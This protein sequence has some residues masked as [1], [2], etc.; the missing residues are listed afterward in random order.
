MFFD[1]IIGS[2]SQGKSYDR[3]VQ[4]SEVLGD[5]KK[6]FITGDPEY[7]K[8]QLQDLM[9]RFNRITSYNVCYTKLLRVAMPVSG[10]KA[11]EIS[12]IDGLT[13]SA[14][15]NAM[16][17]ERSFKVKQL[18]ENEL[19]GI[20]EQLPTPDMFPLLAFDVDSGMKLEE[21]FPGEIELTFDLDIL[22]ISEAFREDLKIVRLGDT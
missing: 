3:L 22:N 6:T 2:I 20:V 8:K 21:Q 18:E 19:K 17:R 9:G 11:F 4:N 16:D 1:K 10:T 5:I 15:E 14:T 13:I 12:P 7:F